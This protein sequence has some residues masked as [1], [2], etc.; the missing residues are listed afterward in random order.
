MKDRI[1]KLAFIKRT[2]RSRERR[3]SK[4]ARFFAWPLKILFPL[5]AVGILAAVLIWPYVNKWMQPKPRED[6][7]K[8]AK[9]KQTSEYDMLGP[10]LNSLNKKGRPFTMRS[11]QAHQVEEGKVDLQKPTGEMHLEDG[12]LLQ[13]W[14]DQG[15]F[16]EQKNILHLVGNVR[17]ITDKGYD[18]RTPS[19][20]ID[21]VHSQGEGHEPVEG[22]G[23]GGEEI[24]AEGFKV[25]DKGDHVD[26]KGRTQIT[27]PAK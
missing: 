5:A 25:T 12:S 21:F 15:H 27:L 13:F 2:D 9:A 8:L 24:E 17:I 19:A 11:K 20:N 26:F 23:P 6:I 16:F 1:T 7:Q 4:I 22:I 10:K 3:R 14:A 18:F